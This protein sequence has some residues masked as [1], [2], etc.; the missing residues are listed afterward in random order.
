MNGDVAMS[1]KKRADEKDDE[2]T[3]RNG[4]V[5][6]SC[7]KCGKKYMSKRGGWYDDHVTTC[8]VEAGEHIDDG[9]VGRKR[10]ASVCPKCGKEYRTKRWFKSHV[11]NCGSGR[12]A[13]AGEE[14]PR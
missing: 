1:R 8:G 5:K 14:L 4:Q 10:K 13:M 12:F 9:G 7:P 11:T 2:N 3:E 6:L